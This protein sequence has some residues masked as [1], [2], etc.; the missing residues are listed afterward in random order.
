MSV[1]V[2]VD[3]IKQMHEAVLG[4][5]LHEERNPEAVLTALAQ[6]IGEIPLVLQWDE[7]PHS[8]VLQELRGNRV[9]FFNGLQPETP[10]DPGSVLTDDGPQ[11]VAEEP[12]L[13]SF[14]RDEFV[15]LFA[16]RNAV[17]LMGS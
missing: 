16:E 7:E 8:V 2:L 5:V 9:V 12:G 14:S 10:S 17:C 3:E 1:E 6:G 15:R 11:R 4:G 13:E